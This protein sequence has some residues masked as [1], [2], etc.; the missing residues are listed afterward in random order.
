[1]TAP[2]LITPNPATDEQRDQIA[3]FAKVA[4]KKSVKTLDLT[5]PGAQRV[6]ARGNELKARIIAAI[7]ELSL[8]LPNLGCFGIADWLALH[9]VVVFERQIVI[10][11]ECPW[12][13]ALLNSPCPFNKSKMIRE[14][15]F[16]FVGLESVNG[17]PLTLL[18]LQKLYPQ[19]G[20]PRFASYAPNSRYSQDRFATETTLRLRWYLLLKDIVPGSESKTF[21]NQEAL[22]PKEYEMPSAVA[23]TAKNLFVF[24]KTGKHANPNRG[25][26]TS[27]LDSV[28][29]R[30][31]VGFCDSDGIR[32][33]GHWGNGPYDLVGVGASRKFDQEPRP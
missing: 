16:G 23:E 5:I 11:G 30:V 19:S 13:D 32:V 15:H 1:M 14:T 9:K 29:R 27:A 22:F 4:A 3:Q 31:I 24:Q 21:P 17:E 25:A 28:S 10:I 26:R 33:H 6:I 20:Q 8:E 18:Q 12:D 2:T 7:N